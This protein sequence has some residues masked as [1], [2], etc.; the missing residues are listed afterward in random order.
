MAA[1]GIFETDPIHGSR[2]SFPG[3]GHLD[4]FRALAPIKFDAVLFEDRRH[5][6]GRGRT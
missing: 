2:N 5:S 1:R 3:L 6:G 4:G